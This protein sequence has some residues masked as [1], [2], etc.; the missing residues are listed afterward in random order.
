MAN[1]IANRPPG[2]DMRAR[3]ANMTDAHTGTSITAGE[4]ADGVS[5]VGGVLL[6]SRPIADTGGFTAA[7]GVA[8][9]R[10]ESG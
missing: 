7:G 2:R 9:A 5:G 10:A 8:P 1:A 4:R 3:F 6:P